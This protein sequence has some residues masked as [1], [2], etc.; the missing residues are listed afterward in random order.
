MSAV[1]RHRTAAASGWAPVLTVLGLSI[2]ALLLLYR[3]T[4]LAMVDIWSRSDTFAHAFT[5]PPIVAWLIWRRRDA[6]AAV[7]PGPSAWVLAPLAFT[8]LLWLLGSL[9]STNAVSQFALTALLVLLIVAMIGVPASRLIAF[10]LAFLFFMVPIGEF[11][12]P[13]MMER[14]ADFTVLALRLTG[15]PVY[16]EG[17]QFVIPSG[18]WSVVEAC[19][20]VRYLIASVMVGTLFAYLNY[21]SLRRRLIFI[22]VSILVPIVANWF[23]A[24]LIVLLGHL[25][26]NKLAAGADHIIYGWVFFGLV[27]MLMFFIGAR[28][29]EAEAVLPPDTSRQSRRAGV[30][31]GRMPAVA[32]GA[33]LL[34]IAPQIAWWLVANGEHEGVPTLSHPSILA[35]GWELDGNDTTRWTPEFHGAATQFNRSYKRQGQNVGLFVAYYRHQDYAQKMVSSN[36]AMVTSHK[37]EWS[38]IEEGSRTVAVDADTLTVRTALLRDSGHLAAGAGTRLVAWQLYWINGTWTASDESAKAWAAL[39]RLLGRGDDAAVVVVYADDDGAGGADKLLQRFLGDNI[40][41]I[42]ARLTETRN[43]PLAASKP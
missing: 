4:A 23:R 19:S 38:R 39:H 3:E 27:I 20:G 18:N 8:G 35:D 22:G 41:T 16:R 7:A 37:T 26:D 17:L 25:S 40:H 42:D 1:Q 29:S 33:A 6:L 11:V 13:M 10:P 34:L 32:L 31:P 2:A 43:T 21:R 36:N 14:T 9:A 24:Y 12:M 5:V 28:W 30:A 15:I